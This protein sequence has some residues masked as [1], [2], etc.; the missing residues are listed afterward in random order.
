MKDTIMKHE[1]RVLTPEAFP[2]FLR[3]IPSPPERLWAMGAFPKKDTKY[4]SVVGSRNISRYG[5]E[6]IAYL[7]EALAPY[8]ITI[9]SGLAR[10]VDG[11]AHRAALRAGLHTIAI[12]GSGLHKSVLY[13]RTHAP[14]AETIVEKGGLLLSEHPPTHRAR[15]YDF[16]SRN[17]IMAGISHATLV[18][19][20]TERSGTLVTARLAVD[21]NRELLCVPHSIFAENGKGS[22]Q[23]IRLGAT[24]VT[25]PED[26]LEALNISRE[27]STPLH[28]ARGNE[29]EVTRHI[30]SLLA[31]PTDRD[32][33]LR[34]LNVPPSTVLQTLM[35][36]ELSGVI[37]E[38]GGLYRRK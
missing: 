8:P 36:L 10:G 20:A 38:S 2:P 18:I 3:E 25:S 4:L 9:V 24:L 11:E 30:L 1:T 13:P 31:E 22:H 23:F 19:E 32:T 26:I 17:R 14:L 12:P 21:Y 35:T 6:V 16:L 28:E 15:A 5:K 7:I 29:S 34:S 37:I 33:L 27:T